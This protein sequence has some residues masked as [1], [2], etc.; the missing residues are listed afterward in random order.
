MKCKTTAMLLVMLLLVCGCAL[1]SIVDRG[2]CGEG[3]S[4]T[5]DSD[6]M[7]TVSG[8]GAMPDYDFDYP[9]DGDAIRSIVIEEGI[10]RV[11]VGAFSLCAQT[12]VEFPDSLREIGTRAFSG[13]E[14]L[15]SIDFGNG[16]RKI[17][18]MAFYWCDGLTRVELPDSVEEIGPEAFSECGKLKSVR[19]GAGLETLDSSAFA[20]CYAMTAFEADENNS[21]FKAVDG[22]LY[23]GAGETFLLCPWG[24]T[25]VVTLADGVTAI[26]NRAFWGCNKL[27]RIVT[28]D[29]LLAIGDETFMG[30]LNLEGIAIGSG[31]AD[32]SADAFVPLWKL[33]SIDVS[34]SNAVYA[35]AG[36]LLY[37]TGF[38]ALICC[39][40][41]RSGR[42]D[43]A[44]GT[45]EIGSTAFKSCAGITELSIP[46]SVKSI[47]DK[48]F[49]DTSLKLVYLYPYS[50]AMTYCEQ[51]KISYKFDYSVSVLPRGLKRID[52]EAFEG[53]VVE[54]LILP[55][56]LETIGD[57]AFAG[58]GISLIDIPESV[59]SIG[60]EAFEG[61]DELT[62]CAIEGSYAA[63]YAQSNDI[64]LVYR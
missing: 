32:I 44:E 57:R 42:V 39:P 31:V 48:A 11:G 43:I 33:S 34:E 58:A 25:G 49:A 26:A 22:L 37:D 54:T 21:N 29:S 5:L 27:S 56:G 55:P 28:P 23:D 53:I 10:T 24:K 7:L 1:A 13:S 36:G 64:P 15:K 12:S 8:E 2:S 61:C 19:F 59:Q 4:W 51:K 9:W 3:V 18:E 16:V 63:S 45:Q 52:A 20:E 62:I 17:G 60:A 30:C 38:Q 40:Q 6:G 35:S 46:K 14:N 41:G 47:A 50:Y